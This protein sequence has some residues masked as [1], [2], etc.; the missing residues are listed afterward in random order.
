MNVKLLLVGSGV[1]LGI[2]LTIGSLVGAVLYIDHE[3]R[4]L[5]IIE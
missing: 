2:A 5:G 1:L 3:E 4:K